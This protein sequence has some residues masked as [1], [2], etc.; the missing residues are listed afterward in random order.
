MAGWGRVV[1]SRSAS[2]G[3]WIFTRRRVWRI[4]GCRLLELT[5]YHA[6]PQWLGDVL[7]TIGA[8]KAVSIVGVDR[9]SEAR[10]SARIEFTPRRSHAVVTKTLGPEAMRVESDRTLASRPCGCFFALPLS[11]EARE[12]AD[13]WRRGNL[14]I[15]GRR[16]P[17]ANFHIT[18]CFLG[19]L[20]ASTLTG[21]TAAADRIA[22]DSFDLTL[23]TPG[24]FPGPRVFWIGPWPSAR[25]PYHAGRIAGPGRPPIGNHPGASTFPPTSHP[26]KAMP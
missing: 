11:A 17:A 26:D 2:S 16:V 19:D 25:Q 3:R 15:E 5:L 9:P 4:P 21:L 22:T 14:L 1:S 6:Y 8:E 23:D 18:L 13:R 12:A 7:G 20:D 24:Y 10:L